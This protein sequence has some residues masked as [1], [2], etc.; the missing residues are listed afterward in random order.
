MIFLALTLLG[1]ALAAMPADL[2]GRWTLD[3]GRSQSVDALLAASG[4]SLVERAAAATMSVT[5]DMRLDGATLIIQVESA[6]MDRE[7]RLPLDGTVVKRTSKRW[8]EFSRR[9]VGANLK[10]VWDLASH[11]TPTLEPPTVESPTVEPP[12]VEPPTVEAG[13][14]PETTPG[15]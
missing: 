15:P 6:V 8:D 10:M 7:E 2:S 13:G 14:T 12:T 5:Q 4:A 11:R 1:A 3:Q 9:E